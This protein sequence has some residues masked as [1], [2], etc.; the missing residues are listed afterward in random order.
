[1]CDGSEESPLAPADTQLYGSVAV[2][3]CCSVGRGP[4]QLAGRCCCGRAVGGKELVSVVVV[5]MVVVV[6]TGLGG[7]WWL[8]DAKEVVTRC[9]LSTMAKLARLT[10]ARCCRPG[11]ER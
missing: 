4:A 8:L 10:G 7:G 5:M 1:M 9:W 11:M 2:A 3:I 6:V